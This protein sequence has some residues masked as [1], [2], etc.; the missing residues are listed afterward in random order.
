MFV[1]TSENR[2]QKAE[3]EVRLRH[4]DDIAIPHFIF[5]REMQIRGRID[6]YKLSLKKKVSRESDEYLSS[7]SFKVKSEKARK[8][9]REREDNFFYLQIVLKL[10]VLN[11]ND[12]SIF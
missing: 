3:G 4:C 8:R 5:F 7:H 9:K 10:Y 1:V 12:R 6:R 2:S 11:F